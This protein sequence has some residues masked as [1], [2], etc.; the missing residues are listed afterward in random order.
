MGLNLARDR[1]CLVQLSFGAG[2]AILVK[3]NKNYDAPNLKKLLKDPFRVKIFHFARFD[4]AS[5]KKFLDVDISN[6][7]CTKIAS[8]LTRTYAEYHGLK[9]LCRDLL[10][11]SI[12]KAQQSTDW[13]ANILT[14]E[15][16][17]YAASDVAYLH[18]L[19]DKLS[20]ML[21]REGRYELALNIFE[22]LPT[23]VALDLW[24]WESQDIFAH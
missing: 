21:K 24:G 14:K 16:Q 4:L 7:F 9:D 11:V 22:F 17:D 8:K 3:F 10:S 23:R 1:L 6:I 15:Q 12:S 13:G 5:I 2:K 20:F 18:A 19:R